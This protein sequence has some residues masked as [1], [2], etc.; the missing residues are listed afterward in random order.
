MRVYTFDNL[1][2]K[3]FYSTFYPCDAML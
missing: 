2:L 3:L 1:E